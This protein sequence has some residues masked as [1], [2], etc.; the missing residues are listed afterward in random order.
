MNDISSILQAREPGLTAISSAGL[1]GSGARIRIRGNASLTQSNEPVIFLDGIRINSGGG[2]TSR[3]EDID[4]ESIERIEVLKGAAA[5]TLYG[6]EAS[7]GVIQVFTKRGSNSATR[8][9]FSLNQEAIKLPDR[10]APNAGYAKSQAQADSLAAYWHI[11]GLKPY[12]VFEVPVWQDY[13]AETGKA[14]TVAGQVNGGATAFTYFASGRYQN[15]DGPIGGKQFGPATDQLKRIQTA[16]NMTLLPFNN[17]RLGLRSG[18]YYTWNAIPAVGSSAT[19][20]TAR[21]RWRR[22]RVRNQRTVINPRT[23][24][25]ANAAARA[26]R[27]ATRPS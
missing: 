4:P 24:H 20:S 7:N 27:S 2:Q 13:L 17:V 1:T 14:S 6:T 22:T 5:A 25:R 11:A 8:W 10:V 23:S 15:E 3:L 26:T 16:A 18:Y 19:A 21:T 12:Q 9:H